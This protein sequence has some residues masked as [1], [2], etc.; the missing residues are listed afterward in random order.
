MYSIKLTCRCYRIRNYHY[1]MS[2]SYSHKAALTEH[3]FYNETYPMRK[4]NI[5]AMYR[6]NLVGM[7]M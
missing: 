4:L 7:H 6:F 5:P 3:L 1:H 2:Q